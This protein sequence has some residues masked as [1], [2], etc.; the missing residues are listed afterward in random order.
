[1]LKFFQFHLISYFVSLVM[2]N[3]AKNL[4]CLKIGSIRLLLISYFSNDNIL[5]CNCVVKIPLSKH[6]CATNLKPL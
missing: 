4:Y 6:R 2:F 1:M 3:Y 5:L